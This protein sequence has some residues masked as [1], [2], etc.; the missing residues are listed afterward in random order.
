MPLKRL[1]VWLLRCYENRFNELGPAVRRVCNVEVAT[2]VLST[3]YE[4]REF[5]EKTLDYVYFES[6]EHL[7]EV[8]AV[9]ENR[10]IA[11]EVDER[12]KRA[13]YNQLLLFSKKG[14]F[15]CVVFGFS[16]V[17]AGVVSA[18]WISLK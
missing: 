9:T 1:N 15:W 2:N 11:L 5:W 6:E 4:Q 7:S 10:V 17:D 14:A 18:I 3:Q 12:W 8:T 16:H 13:S